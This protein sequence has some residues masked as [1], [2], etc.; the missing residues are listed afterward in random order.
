[1]MR[2]TQYSTTELVQLTIKIIEDIYY[3]DNGY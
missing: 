2:I 3:T 1:M